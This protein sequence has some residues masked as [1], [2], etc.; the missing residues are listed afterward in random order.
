MTT[1]KPGWASR[2]VTASIG[3]GR[4]S[5]ENTL[6]GVAINNIGATKS[7][8]TSRC[9]VATVS[10]TDAAMSPIGQIVTMRSASN[11]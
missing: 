10:D 9:T 1:A 11:P 3:R 8:M 4:V 2:R 5:R 7:M 6:V